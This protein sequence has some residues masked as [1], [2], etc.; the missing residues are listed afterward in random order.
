MLGHLA[1]P[2][3]DLLVLRIIERLTRN[4]PL[5]QQTST[6]NASATPDRPW[7]DLAYQLIGI[8]FALVPVVLALYLLGLTHPAGGSRDRVRPAARFRPVLRRRDRAGIAVPG[9]GALPRRA[10]AR[11]EYEGA[12][13]RSGRQLVDHPGVDLV[14]GPERSVEEVIIIGYLFTRL[15]QLGWRWP[16]I[17]L[18][19]AIVRGSYHLYQG[20]GGFVGNLI[21]GVIFGLIYLRSSE[22]GRWCVA[23]TLLDVAAFV[24]YALVAPHVAGSDGDPATAMIAFSTEAT[25]ERSRG[26]RRRFAPN[27]HKRCTAGP[28][29]R[30]RAR[31]PRRRRRPRSWGAPAPPGAAGRR[32]ATR[33]AQPRAGP[34]SRCGGS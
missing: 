8:G 22:W 11:A 15:R 7:L 17:I 27:G 20:F 24:G 19:S 18:I 25:K 26:D 5:A 4:V 6:L 13:I 9:L 34:G 3:G 21:M 28:S 30:A 12:G 31:W 16:M 1:G 14:R 33:P 23:H 10:G 29:R 2:V 32:P